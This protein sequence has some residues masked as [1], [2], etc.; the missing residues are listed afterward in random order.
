MN[1]TFI[2][3]ENNIIQKVVDGINK[4]SNGYTQIGDSLYEFSLKLLDLVNEAAPEYL[5]VIEHATN[6]Y[7]SVVQINYD[8]GKLLK[9][10]AEDI[11]DISERAI[12]IQRLTIQYQNNEKLL[13]KAKIEYGKN[14]GRSNEKQLK[15]NAE[16]SLNNTKDSLK[17]LIEQRTKFFSFITRRVSHAISTYASALKMSSNKQVD[18]MKQVS[19]IFLKEAIE[20]KI[21][22]IQEN[23]CDEES[24]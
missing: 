4:Q 16:K 10:V 3:P 9:R 17:E 6:V 8:H 13:E 1:K 23:D 24:I 11:Q 21:E 12:V 5:D 15:E 18:L 22:Y 14:K 2:S 20:K 7:D 19:D